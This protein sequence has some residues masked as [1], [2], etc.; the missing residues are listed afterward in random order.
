MSKPANWPD[1]VPYIDTSVGHVGVSHLRQMNATGLRALNGIVVVHDS[2]EPLA[3]LV[4]Y[5]TFLAIDDMFA[6]IDLEYRIL[7]EIARQA[8]LYLHG[9]DAGRDDARL[10]LELHLG[11]LKAASG[12]RGDK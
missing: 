10:S 9:S 8:D 7:T 1:G 11:K 6:E 4:P 3:V 2:S 5:E 12:D